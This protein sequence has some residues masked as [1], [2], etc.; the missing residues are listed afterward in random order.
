MHGELR[1]AEPSQYRC[2][3]VKVRR[4]FHFTLSYIAYILFQAYLSLFLYNL[5]AHL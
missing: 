1:K 3:G 4:S 2:S 5:E